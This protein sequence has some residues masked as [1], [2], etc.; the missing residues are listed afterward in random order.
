MEQIK[1]YGEE[2]T[3]LQRTS[4]LYSSYLSATCM[5]RQVL[6]CQF[7]CQFLIYY[8]LVWFQPGAFW[9]V[10]YLLG[11]RY[12]SAKCLSA[13]FFSDMCL[14]AGWFLIC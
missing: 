3:A 2:P 13:N 7:V 11:T 6:A 1:L 4:Y 5:S 8:V 9:Q 14:S 10:A 12:S